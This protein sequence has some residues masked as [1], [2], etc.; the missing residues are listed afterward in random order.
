MNSSGL[1]NSI[2]FDKMKIVALAGGVGG[3]KLVD[4]LAR[5]LSSEDLTVVVNT[6]DDFEHF[7]LTIC[8][9][10]DTVCYTLAQIANPET[11]WGR[12]DESLHVLDELSNLEAPVWFKLGDK[13]LAIHLER[14]RLLKSGYSLLEVVKKFLSIWGVKNR[15]LPM[16]NDPCP[17]IVEIE[18]GERLPFQEYFVKYQF[19][20]RV[21][22]FDFSKASAATPCPGVLESIHKSDLVI[23][24]PSN[25]FVSIDPILQ[26]PGIK[27]AIK[28]KKVL[29]VSPIIAGKAI[30]GPA[31]KMYTDF[32]VQPSALAVAYHYKDLIS[33]FMI[34]AIDSN[35][36]NEIE[37][38]GII[39]NMS[40]IVMRNIEDRVRLA[41]ETLA[42]GAKLI[43]G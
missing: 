9:D 31:A 42:F 32:G 1:K 43:S 26:V 6:G 18:D 17:T 10:L 28:H 36:K 37:Q 19:N 15:V 40:D 35:L 34:D 16:S 38:C 33:G 14:T 39:L 23:I 7:G 2:S 8:P 5:I 25:P 12:Q 30:K 29:A 22:G 4:G 3:A 13:D 11:G 24:C 20:P 21:M 27:D 41:K